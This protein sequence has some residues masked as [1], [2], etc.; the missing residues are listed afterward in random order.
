M[1]TYIPEVHLENI[2]PSCY[3]LSMPIYEYRCSEC[4]GITTE[5]VQGFNDPEGLTCKVCGSRK[6]KRMVSRVNSISSQEERLESYNPLARHDDSFY[7]DTRNIGLHAEYMLKKAGIKPT[8]DF[9][10]KLEK[11]RTDPSSVIKDYE[12]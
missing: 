8:E 11:V 1:R 12:G 7:R 10:S 2:T 9:K 5:F 6:L 4:G 3:I